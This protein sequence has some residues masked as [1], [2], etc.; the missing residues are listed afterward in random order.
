MH[1]LWIQKVEYKGRTFALAPNG[2]DGSWTF[3]EQPG[4]HPLYLA[5]SEQD[6]LTKI[7]AIVGAPAHATIAFRQVCP[8]CH[9]PF[10]CG[11]P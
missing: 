7:G 10:A 1:S 2:P 5:D 9:S 4:Y 6:A 8:V 11:C 3:T